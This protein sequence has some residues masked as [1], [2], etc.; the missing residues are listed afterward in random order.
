MILALM[1]AWLPIPAIV[2]L[3]A[4]ISMATGTG[5]VVVQTLTQLIAGP[6][7]LGSI[8]ATV[9]LGR[10]LGA[11]FGAALAGAALFAAINVADPALAGIFAE[12]MQRGPALLAQLPAAR[13][14]AVQTELA[15]AFRAAYLT[16]ACVAATGS[17]LAWVI[18]TR[19]I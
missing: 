15:G 8:A 14:A 17:L 11:S 5:M 9:Q 2:G 18:P 3:L 1:L 10:S 7:Q 6:R 16:I 12:L 13:Q 19:K 4:L